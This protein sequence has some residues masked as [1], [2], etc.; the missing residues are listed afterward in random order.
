MTEHMREILQRNDTTEDTVS[1]RPTEDHVSYAETTV[2][3]M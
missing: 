3:D 2:S 1:C